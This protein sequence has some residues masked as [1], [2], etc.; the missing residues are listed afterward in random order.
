MAHNCPE[1]GSQCYCGG[2]YDD[3][4]LEGTEAE[5]L[6]SCCPFYEEDEDNFEIDNLPEEKQ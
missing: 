4:L 1:C 2:D 6:C 3:I 5:E